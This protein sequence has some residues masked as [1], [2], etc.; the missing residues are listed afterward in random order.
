MNAYCREVPSELPAGLPELKQM[1]RAG[2]NA[3]GMGSRL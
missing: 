1:K 2:T 3:D